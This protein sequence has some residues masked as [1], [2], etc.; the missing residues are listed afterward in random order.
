MPQFHFRGRDKTGRL[1]VGQ[2]NADSADSLNLDLTREG[3]IVIEIKS[4][5]TKQPYQKRIHDWLQGDSFHL[6]EL[7]VFSRQMKLL[8]RA[9][10]PIITSLQQLSMHI[11]SNRLAYAIH[12]IIRQIEKG[13][14]LANS[15]KQYSDIFSPLIISLIQIGENTGKLSEAFAHI[16]R[17]LDFEVQT[18]KQ[19]KAAFRYPIFIFSAVIV[20]LLILNLFV[21]PTFA[22]FY[23]SLNMPL[24][25]QTRI[26]ISTSNFFVNYSLVL[27]AALLIAAILL[28]RYIHT[29][30]GKLR[31]DYFLLK[32][33][34]SGKML[35]R[36]YL[37]RLCDSLSI[38]LSS[39]IS[40]PQGLAL[41]KDTIANTY[42]TK[43]LVIM[44]ANIERGVSFTQAI[45]KVD[46]MTRL[47]TQILAV[48]ERNGEL[49]P[50]FDYIAHFH[51]EEIQYD[52]KRINDVV[53]PILIAI[54]AVL[55]LI[56]ALGIYLPVWNMIDLIKH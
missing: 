29:E 7:A 24:P 32:I 13:Q 12:G 36:I 41:T 22:T 6:S 4:E 15:M 55:I 34:F 48:G 21:I 46:L 19:V 26:L 42:I 35:R 30:R 5:S 39:G 14:S 51:S 37:I 38:V 50:A 33:P 44:R 11:R 10:V 9:G 31:W 49:A 20:A 27:L 45:E 17:Y 25:W 47:E 40:L 54:V 16:E 28:Y 56:V 1:L 52:I 3:I 53:G 43:Q 18:M 23:V 2:R 8:H